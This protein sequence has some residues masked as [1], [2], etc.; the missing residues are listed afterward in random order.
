MRKLKI[1]IF[2]IVFFS[3]SF[4]LYAQNSIPGMENLKL[5]KELH[6]SFMSFYTHH[7][8]H[9]AKNKQGNYYLK[10]NQIMGLHNFDYNNDGFEDVMIEFY[11]RP[12]NSDYGVYN[13]AVLF[14]NAKSKYVYI[15]HLN[16]NEVSFREYINSVF[17][18][19]GEVH[20]FT[21]GMT[22]EKYILH[23]D[24]FVRQ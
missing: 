19:Y 11:V 4:S 3:V 13:I 8:K 17:Y 12:S 15:A 16:P 21:E 5:N 2:T 14:K 1:Y 9:K 22:S 24:K 20:S 6:T 23:V 7:I 18:F 10:I